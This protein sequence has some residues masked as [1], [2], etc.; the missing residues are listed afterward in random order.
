MTETV[1]I[2]HQDGRTVDG[3]EVYEEGKSWRVKNKFDGFDIVYRS[4]YGWR[5]YQ[6]EPINVTGECKI[7]A[8]RRTL[9]IYAGAQSCCLTLPTGYFWRDVLGIS[10]HLF[11]TKDVRP[12]MALL[13]MKEG[14]K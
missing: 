5:E 9:D 7:S 8:D 1:K 3:A 2:V 10:R 12:F 14:D 4:E 13:I 6:P 11:L